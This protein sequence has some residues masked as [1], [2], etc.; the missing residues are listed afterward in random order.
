MWIPTDV[1]VRELCE[2]H[3]CIPSVLS[4]YIWWDVTAYITGPKSIAS[5]SR[6]VKITYR[7]R[8]CY[9]GSPLIASKV[10]FCN[11]D[12][13]VRV[14]EQVENCL[15]YTV[16]VILWGPFTIRGYLTLKYRET[17]GCVVSTVAID[18]LVL[19]HQ[20]ISVLSADQTF[21]VLDQ[22]YIKILH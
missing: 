21:I 20:V 19:K 18:A 2:G 8:H 5:S 17:H 4:L 13:V 14:Q 1:S 15:N 3:Y 10:F 22:F 11:T 16:R 7:S 12:R 9:E 6:P